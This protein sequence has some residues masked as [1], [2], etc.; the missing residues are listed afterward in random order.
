MLLPLEEECQWRECVDKLLNVE[1][2]N[3]NSSEI[4]KRFS[5]R[6]IG[7]ELEKIYTD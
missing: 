4:E 6:E 2:K 1:R 5:I 7:K 3:I